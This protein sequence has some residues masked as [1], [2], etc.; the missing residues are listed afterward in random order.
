MP[1]VVQ[2]N[3]VPLLPAALVA[4]V[5]ATFGC[6]A[7]NRS[8]PGSAG[9]SDVNAALLDAVDR[10]DIDA[11]RAMLRR[12]A[13]P[14]HVDDGRPLLW[15]AI[16]TGNVILVR[17][18]LKAGADI[19]QRTATEGDSMLGTAAYAGGVLVIEALL[20]AG[21]DPN[22]RFRGGRLT[23][24]GMAALGDQGMVC[25]ALIKAG[26]DPNGWNLWPTRWYGAERPVN[27]A[28]RGR[29]AL[30]IAASYGYAKTTALLIYHGAD[31][32]LKNERGQSALDLTSEYQ[33]PMDELRRL[34][35][36]PKL[37]LPD[38]R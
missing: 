36:R 31:P 5:L 11:L 3:M 26:A 12:G 24:L 4:V 25:S 20:G 28:R 37:V 38:K 29:T 15:Y 16:N 22:E 19:H 9:G 21:A 13:S 18:L 34:L 2:R 17:E 7:G 35:Q 1:G 10:Q 27:G 33:N 14:N 6:S 23:A 8:T 32:F 30:M